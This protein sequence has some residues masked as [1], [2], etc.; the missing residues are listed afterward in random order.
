MPDSRIYDLTEATQIRASDLFVLE[1]ESVAKKLSGQTLTN[2]L[3]ELAD[4][5][6]GIRSIALVSTNGL[7]KTYRITYTDTSTFDFQVSDGSQGVQGERGYT[8]DPASLQSSVVVYATSSSGVNPPSGVWSPTLPTVQQ[9]YYL[10]TKITLVF[11]SGSPIVFYTVAR[12]GVD[13]LGSV[14]SINNVSP[15]SNGNVSLD[16]TH[17]DNNGVPVSQQLDTLEALM[18]SSGESATNE[19]LQAF[20]YVSSPNNYV[21]INVILPKII[22]ASSSITVTSIKLAMCIPAGGYL[23]ETSTTEYASM[24]NSTAVKGNILTIT[25]NKS[26]GWGVNAL[27]P[28]AGSVTISYLIS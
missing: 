1:Q 4:G 12:S 19:Y 8:G 16:A 15:D 3:L 17:I 2:K 6:G 11:N 14:S 27:T 24:I 10:W 13:G 25:L 23:N 21:A 28:I 18:Y 20:G 5:H 7:V 22:K 9:G 26:G